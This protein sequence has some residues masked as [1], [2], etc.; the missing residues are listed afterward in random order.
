MNTAQFFA[1]IRRRDSGVFGTSL[2]QRQVDGIEAIL[3]AG[4]HL[5]RPHLAHVLGEV[6][7]ETGGGMYPIKET[8]FRSH[9]NQNPSDAEVIARLDRAWSKGQLPWV[10][11]AYW[12]S[13]FFGRGQIQL[14]HEANYRK[15]SPIVGVDLVE[16][17]SRALD[18]DVSATIS[19]VGCER[20]L[21]T[22]KRLSDYDTP[23][24]FD[25]V[26]ARRIVN[27]FV[28]DQ[29]NDV[30]KAAQAFAAAL[31]EAGHAPQGRAT[32]PKSP[33]SA[34]TQPKQSTGLLAALLTGLARY[35]SGR[36]K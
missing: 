28:R 19:V 5:I 22:G 31:A 2:S 8:V 16:D 34:P 14:T 9:T 20:G 36:S 27:G 15:F 35:F 24:G 32:A 33:S 21:F 29:A 3:K 7:H 23:N 30:A 10:T 17:P 25:H 18:L 12:R 1:S 11:S 26:Q 4:Q 13:G 6:Y